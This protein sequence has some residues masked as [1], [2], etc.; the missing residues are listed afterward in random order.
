MQRKILYLQNQY[1]GWGI[2][3]VWLLP[4]FIVPLITFTLYWLYKEYT[5]PIKEPTKEEMEERA[6]K[7]KE[8]YC[9][10]ES[11]KETERF[12]KQGRLQ[13]NRVLSP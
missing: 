6:R 11:N 10:E 12:K 9:G 5:D 8:K 3:L 2:K 13:E 7:L 1:D 4:F